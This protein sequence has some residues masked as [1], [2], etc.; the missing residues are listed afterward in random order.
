LICNR[1]IWWAELPP[2]LASELGYK[3]PV[4]IIQSN[5]FNKSDINTTIC[6]AITSNIKLAKAPGNIILLKENSKLNKDSVINISQI[7]TV[8]K[9]FLT[10][11]ITKLSYSMMKKIET[12]L[13]LLFE[14]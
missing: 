3:R 7:I 5:D 9:I 2:P 4:L 1:E 13:K 6:I 12:G 8:D 11:K 10:K 14:I